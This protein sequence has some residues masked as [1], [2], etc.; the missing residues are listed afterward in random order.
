MNRRNFIKKGALFV[1][2][3]FAPK[4]IRAQYLAP[5]S[6]IAPP[7]PYYTTGLL[8]WYRFLEGTGTTANDSSGN[9]KTGTLIN[10][11]SGYPTWGTGPTAVGGSLTFDGT[12]NYVDT[13]NFAD[14]P[15]NLSVCCWLKTTQSTSGGREYAAVCKLGSSIESGTGWYVTQSGDVLAN[16]AMVGVQNGGGGDFWQIY[17]STA[18]NDGNW[19]HVVLLI[20]A[21]GG[22][23]GNITMYYDGVNVGTGNNQ[24][25]GTNPYGSISN[26]S[27]VRIGNDY[28]T[29]GGNPQNWDGPIAD[30]RIYSGV[31]SSTIIGEIYAGTA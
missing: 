20:S 30:V 10:G 19:H 14:N 22:A 24:V 12:D 28:A 1:P 9:S 29:F 6:Y 17:S 11:G 16:A 31:L 26:T 5:F 8:A 3:I 15:T 7:N 4:L 13:S 25:V 27:N 21:S 18:C 2:M 23:N